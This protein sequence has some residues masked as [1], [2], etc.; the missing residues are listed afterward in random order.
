M[1]VGVVPETAIDTLLSYAYSYRGVQHVELI[2][3]QDDLNNG[4]A[5]GVKYNVTL[6]SWLYLKWQAYK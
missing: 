2:I 1:E 4:K 3:D 6:E 5:P